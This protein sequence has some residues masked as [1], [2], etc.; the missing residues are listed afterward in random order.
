MNCSNVIKYSNYVAY[1]PDGNALAIAKGVNLVVYA[2]PSM[3]LLFKHAFSSNITYIQFSNDSSMI[4][5]GLFKINQCEIISVFN[6]NTLVKINESIHGITNIYWCPCNSKL[7][8]VSLYNTK[9]T[10]WNLIDQSA[11]QIIN[12]ISLP[13]YHDKGIEFSYD[14]KFLAVTERKDS[15]DYIGIYFIGNFKLM[16]HFVLNTNDMQDMK[17]SKDN[18]YLIVIDSVTDNGLYVYSIT[19]N[20]LFLYEPYQDNFGAMSLQV[21]PCGH[22]ISVGYGDNAVRLFHYITYK[23]ICELQHDI[24]LQIVKDNKVKIFKEEDITV[25]DLSQSKTSKFIEV[26]YNNKLFQT[27]KSTSNENKDE[28]NYTEGIS[29]IEYSSGSKFIATK[30]NKYHNII[31]IWKVSSLSLFSVII[32]N[33]NITDFKWSPFI[34]SLIIGTDNNKCYMYNI[35]NIYIIDLPSTPDFQVKK[36]T[37]NPDGKTFLLQDKY[38]LIL[39]FSDIEL[40]D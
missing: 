30:S 9:I 27:N 35:N 14:E 31:W 17:W 34:L 23:K 7:L 37:W 28:F 13:K 6:T 33:K 38:K 11:N 3:T 5:V 8:T 12:Y 24:N 2:S 16:S 4:A 39:C 29:H 36:I 40:F 25:D 32:L 1:S 22:F 20:L 10:V 18:T 15:K 19:G 26:E 21:S